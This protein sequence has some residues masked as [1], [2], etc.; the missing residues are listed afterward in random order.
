MWL[1]W[2]PPE[3]RKE[4]QVSGKDKAGRGRCAQNCNTQTLTQS[5]RTRPLRPPPP[6][7]AF[8]IP[9]PRAA[10]FRIPWGPARAPR[11][12]QQPDPSTPLLLRAPSWP[13]GLTLFVSFRYL[14]IRDLQRLAD[15][16]QPSLRVRKQARSLPLPYKPTNPPIGLTPLFLSLSSRHSPCLKASGAGAAQSRSDSPTPSCLPRPALPFRGNPNRGTAGLLFLPPDRPDV[17]PGPPSV[18]KSTKS[19]CRGT[20]LSTS[21]LGHLRR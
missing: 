4:G 14:P 6:R 18:G 3:S 9:G 8:P 7:W 21:S 12:S 20:D 16:G 2:A 10:R 1:Q 19:S 5:K 13:T 11:L 15:Q 17:A